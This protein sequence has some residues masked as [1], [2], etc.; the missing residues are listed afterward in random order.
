[1]IQEP[2]FNEQ[3]NQYLQGLVPAKSGL[4]NWRQYER[5]KGYLL[6]AVPPSLYDAAI[7][8]LADQLHI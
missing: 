5:A 1:M 7:R 6:T 3:V 8:K 4:A 2:I